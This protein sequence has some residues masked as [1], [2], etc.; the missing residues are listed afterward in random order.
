MKPVVIYGNQSSAREFFQCLR[1]WSDIEVAGFTVDRSYVTSPTFCDLPLVPFDEVQSAF[2][3][4]SFRMF[5]A[6]G[7]VQNNRIRQD[8]CN[9][10][11][12]LGYELLSYTSPKAIVLPD[13]VV[14]DN[15]FIDHYA[16]VSS[17]CRVGNGTIIRTGCLIGHDVSIAD[18]CFFSPGVSVGGS[19]TIGERCYFSLSSI[20]RSKVVIGRECV[21]GAGA[22][23]MEDAKDGSVYHAEPAALLPIP[24]NQLPL[25]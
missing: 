20:L 3:P 1:G 5:V 4:S 7:Y 6:V 15:C 22:V 24:A 12:D 25:A 9:R 23:L 8:R 11:R 21:V 13:V 16:V 18:Y 2:S 19:V 10:A 17:N 14:G